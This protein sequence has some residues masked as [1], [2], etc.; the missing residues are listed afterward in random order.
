MVYRMPLICFGCRDA[1]TIG[2]VHKCRVYRGL[3]VRMDKDHNAKWDCGCEVWMIEA[4][5]R[6][7]VC[8]DHKEFV[9]RQD[10][11]EEINKL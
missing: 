11:I 7:D 9:T 2:V 4:G 6:V 10:E 1:I 5:L 3:H 8:E